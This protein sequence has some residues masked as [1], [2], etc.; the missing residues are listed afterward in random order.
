MQNNNCQ[1]CGGCFFR[2]LS[3]QEYRQN[4][5]E[6]FKKIIALVKEGTPIFDA[7]VFIKDGNR[8]RADM[9][10]LF[11]KKQLKLGFNEARSHNLVDITICPM[12]DSQLNE[13]INPLR[14]FLEEFCSLP[15]KV[16][17]KKKKFDT[18]YIQEGSI[19]LLS[20]DNGIDILLKLPLEPS[21]EHRFVTAD[22]VNS[23]EGVC[24][25]SWSVANNTPET[26]VE[27]RSPEL[28]IAK[29]VVEVPQGVFL[30]ASKAAETAMIEIVLNYMGD[31]TGKVADLFCGLGTFT[32]PLAQIKGS[33][34]IAAD[35][36]AASL[37]GLQ[38]AL[39][40]NQIHNVKVVNRNLFKNPF[41]AID[42]KG[43]HALVIDPPRAGAHEQCREIANLASSD[44]PVKI[45]FISCNPKTF[46]YDAEQLIRAGYVFERVT[47]IDQFVYSKHQE[48]IALFTYN[49]KNE[50]GA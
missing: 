21:L 32:Y 7:P 30:Q 19:Q 37:K 8:R 31:T 46:V 42:M 5:I 16:K 38:K 39:N 41:D 29:Q 36:S 6:D 28:Y 23:Q 44:K 49:P 22:F 45:I 48:L 11:N 18:L 14:T 1:Q 3:E 2:N 13:I 34:I 27:K 10:F 12:L 40:R 26:I 20:A 15:L 35:S 33:E 43:I 17:N 50:K 47:L 4:K 24:R 9:A 25:L